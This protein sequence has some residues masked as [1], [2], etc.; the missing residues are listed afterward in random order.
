MVK[1]FK[2]ITKSGKDGLEIICRLDEIR[3]KANHLDSKKGTNAEYN[4][5]VSGTSHDKSA[6]YVEAYYVTEEEFRR[7]EAA[8]LGS[9]NSGNSGNSGKGD[10]LEKF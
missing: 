7:I 3:L 6:D 2:F 10:I 5:L 1:F 4:V 8:L 9:G